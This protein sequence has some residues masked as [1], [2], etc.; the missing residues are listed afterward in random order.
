MKLVPF[1]HLIT[2]SKTLHKRM[3]YPPMLSAPCKSFNTF[4]MEVVRY[5]IG[6]SFA[7]V[8]FSFHT[9]YVFSVFIYSFLLSNKGGVGFKLSEFLF[10][11]L[12][13]QNFRLVLNASRYDDNSMLHGFAI[14]TAYLYSLGTIECLLNSIFCPITS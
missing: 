9:L 12:K 8:T 14:F 13:E 5:C 3:S 4:L 10:I 7:V 11:M 6:I 2:K 1:L